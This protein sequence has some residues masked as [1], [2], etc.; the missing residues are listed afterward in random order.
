[1]GHGYVTLC[2]DNFDE[3]LFAN[4]FDQFANKGITLDHPT[5]GH[6]MAVTQSGEQYLRN[7]EWLIKQIQSKQQV[8]FQWWFDEGV[9]VFTTLRHFSKCSII[10]F[11]L[12]GLTPLQLSTV[13][14]ILL[15]FSTGSFMETRL[16]SLIFDKFGVAED[17]LPDWISS[18]SE[19]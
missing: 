6:V 12:D 4:L 8:S 1:M 11:G 18:F 19:A 9:D 3:I 17:I 7:K 16:L 2:L 10:E 14:S 5:I 13:T 15:L